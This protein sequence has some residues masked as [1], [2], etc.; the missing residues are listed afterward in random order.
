MAVTSYST[1]A[2]NNNSAAPNGAPEG[3][4]P[5][6]V[7]DTIRQIMADI[8][9]E[10]QTNA[11][12]TLSSVSGADTITASMSPALTAYVAG[13]A[14]RW[15]PASNNATTTPTLNINSLGAKTIAKGNVAA[16][17]AA[18]MITT[19][20]AEAIYDGTRFVLQN[21]Q[22]L[23]TTIGGLGTMSTQN[24]NAVAITGGSVTGIT[25]IAVADGGTGASTAANARTN[26]GVTA[27]GADTTYCFRS[28]NLS[29]V[30]AATARS[31][32]G[33][34]AT[35][36]DTT[37]AFRSNN[38]SDLGSAS[39]ARSNLGLVAS[40]TTDTTNASNIS[41]GTLASARHPNIG[42]LP[43]ITIQSDPGGTPSG[44][45]GAMFFYY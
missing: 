5:S 31:N 21:P 17:A 20:Y 3:M 14:V 34:T 35:G 30:T 38:L 2:A 33:V 8:A 42:T 40:A 4:A 22:S 37:Y 24:A 7:N 23:F 29:D 10:A 13:M 19:A 25:D 1:I 27:T 11:V 18:D 36:A 43:G 45:V 16:V 44:A 39:T 41:S 28:N 9:V 12:K 15:L 32:L 26:L 6:G